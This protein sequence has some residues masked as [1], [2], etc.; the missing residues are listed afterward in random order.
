MGDL[1]GGL[2]LDY[3]VLH[4]QVATADW[5]TIGANLARQTA[6][7]LGDLAVDVQHVGSTSVPGLLAKPIID[8]AVGLRTVDDFAA[9]EQVLT[10]HAWIYRGDSGDEGGHLFVLESKPWVR[11]AHAHAVAHDDWQWNRYLQFR[12]HLRSNATARESYAA[13]KAALL[14]E[15]G[16]NGIRE[17]YT[18]RKTPIVSALLQH[19]GW[20]RPSQ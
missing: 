16:T 10:E 17:T 20:S 7:A 4:L 18:D 1:G 2:G 19:S 11:V 12:D 9:A 6:T 5:Q 3:D 8:L 14:A 13:A 15:L